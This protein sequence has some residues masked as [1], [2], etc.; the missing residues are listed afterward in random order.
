MAE[1][2]PTLRFPDGS[3]R[4]LE[5]FIDACAPG[6]TVEL[7]PGRF[8]GPI[9]ITKPINLRG[10]GDLTRVFRSGP[11]RVLDVRLDANESAVVEHVLL[12]GGEAEAGA[13]VRLDGGQLRLHNVHIQGC[14]S[15]G[16]GGGA[17]CV[18]GGTLDASILR[19][20]DVSGDVGGAIWVRGSG[21]MKLSDSQITSSEAL[22]GGALA[23][24]DQGQVALE[25]V[26]V[27]KARA[28]TP[29]GGQALYVT[30][31][32]APR[33]RL[34]MRRVRLEDAPFGMPLFVDPKQPADVS[35]SGCDMPRV[36]QGVSGVIDAGDNHWR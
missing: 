17:I 18:A 20:H 7:A 23:V 24:Q 22:R 19:V 9:R 27:A 32:G 13:G 8:E 36:V 11:G 25:A 6:A 1:P 30:G 26:T 35:L 16:G 33:A 12:E 14:H 2:E 3:S 10:A 29:S 34:S 5:A 21:S 4:S 15:P 28:T 31:G